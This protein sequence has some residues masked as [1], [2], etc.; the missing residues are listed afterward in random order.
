MIANASIDRAAVRWQRR[1]LWLGAIA[2]LVCALG[3]PISPPQFFRAY[4]AAYLFY[5]GI[6]LGSMMMLMVY[7]LT[8]G[9]W[10]LLIRR[11]LEAGMKTLPLMA[12]LF[13]PIAGGI[14]YLYPWAQPDIVAGSKQLQ[15]Q[16]FY[17]YP[18]YFW[19]RAAVYFALWMTMAFLL[20]SWSRQE[21]QTGDPRLAWKGL[22]LSGFGAVLYGI[23]I[24]FAAVDWSMSLEPV[25]H[26]TIWGPL[27]ALGQLLSALSFALVVLAW[28]VERPPLSEVASL[29]VRNDLGSL[30]LTILIVWAYM[31]WFQFML[32]WIANL[33]VDVIW[34][35][36][37]ASAGW[38]SVMWAIVVLHFAIPFF[39]LLMRSI[40]RNS[41]AVARIAGLILLM[42][43]VFM[44]Y[45]VMPGLSA[46]GMGEHWMDFLTPVGIGGIWL[47]CFLWQVQR[48]PLLAPHDYNRA[49]ALHL[50]H[51]DDEE[52]AREEMPAYG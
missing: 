52:A 20:S 27:F 26:S 48:Q 30:L 3:S 51:L 17:L 49:A 9:S 42:Q 24:H 37:R 29:H 14:G 38:K 19:L 2:L 25:F 41:K 45:Q 35:L 10:G 6:A 5:L 31:A 1:S 40:K 39:L 46:E 16:Q 47:A 8:G 22:Q 33:P 36:P 11:I 32:V 34:Y 44:Y 12:L 23:S 21:D 7:H 50:R 13:L 28:L 4:L 43:L 15:Y 18:T